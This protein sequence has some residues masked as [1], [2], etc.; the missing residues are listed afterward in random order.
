MAKHASAGSR[1]LKLAGMT[2]SITS[3]A[4]RNQVTQIRGSEEDKAQARSQMYQEIGVQISQTLGQ[5]KGAVMKVGQALSQFKDI[6]PPELSEALATLQQSAPPM[7]FAAIKHQVE[8]ELKNKLSNIYSEFEPTPFAAASIGQVH[9]AKLKD[10][11][12]VVVKVQYPGVD[13]ACKSDLRQVRALLRLSG[14]LQVSKESQDAMFNEL[15]QTLFEE[16]DYLQEAHNLEVFAKFHAQRDAKIIIPKVFKDYTSKRVLTLSEETGAKIEQ[17]ATWE[18]PLR[19]E[20]G[21][22]LYTLIA[23]QIFLLNTFHCDPHPGNFAFRPDGCVVVYDFGGVK[24]LEPSIVNSFKALTRSALQSD[25]R[26]LEFHLRALKIRTGHKPLA[27]D[28]YRN[29]SKLLTSPLTGPFDFG[30]SRVHKDIIPLLADALKYRGEFQPSGYT[31]MSN[32]TVSGHYWNL[33]ALKVNTDFSAL[34]EFYS[35]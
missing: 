32:R 5:M 20:L 19:N 16:L 12:P 35:Q 27:T 25:Y 7:A 2:A 30:Q 33:M 15:E 34:T 31:L 14:L 28:F 13:A 11:T 10:G 4:I 17:A 23:D 29:W 26:N 21:A 24:A 8:I 3:K 1:F 6:L 18:Q 9:R 22:R